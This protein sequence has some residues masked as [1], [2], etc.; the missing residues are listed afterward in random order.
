MYPFCDNMINNYGI[1][2]LETFSQSWLV[3]HPGRI[4][5][6]GG[7]RVEISII[8]LRIVVGLLRIDGGEVG[9]GASGPV[10]ERVEGGIGA[11]NMTQPLGYVARENSSQVQ[12][13][14]GAPGRG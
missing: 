1:H 9:V 4:T 2:G 11:G 8:L 10:E 3:R 6:E 5:Q 14:S 13:L 12:V 7:K